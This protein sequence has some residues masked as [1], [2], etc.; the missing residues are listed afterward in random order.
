MDS[1]PARRPAGHAFTLIWSARVGHRS[2]FNGLFS[3]MVDARDYRL[4]CSKI[5]AGI[6]VC[7]VVDIS[8]SSSSKVA[9]DMCLRVIQPTA[10]VSRDLWPCPTVHVLQSTGCW[11]LSEPT[12][13]MLSSAHTSKP[14]CRPPDSLFHG[15][16][17]S[18]T[19]ARTSQLAC[20]P[21]IL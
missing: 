14:H 8:S 2:C 1:A 7:G 13:H 12:L 3:L 21:V 15:T 4:I 10:G 16:Q 11:L 17:H 19:A 9:H 5:G 18:N 6:R 20:D